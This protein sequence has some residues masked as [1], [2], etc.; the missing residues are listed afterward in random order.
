MKSLH[1]NKSSLNLTSTNAVRPELVEGL[2]SEK[3]MLRRAQH[4]RKPALT[5]YSLNVRERAC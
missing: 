1:M 4:E 5:D 2:C 3:R